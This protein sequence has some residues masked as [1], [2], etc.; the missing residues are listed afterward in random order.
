AQR[1]PSTFSSR[2][3][4][5]T[6]T[7]ACRVVL[8]S[9]DLNNILSPIIMGSEM[10]SMTVKDPDEK[11]TLAIIQESAH[12]GA[13][14]IRQLLTFA[15][16]TEAKKGPVQPRH[17]LKEITRL[18]KQTFPKNIEIYSDYEIRSE[19]MLADPSQFHQVLMNLCVNAR[20][21]MPEGGIL[22]IKL[23]NIKIEESQVSIH[24]AARP[25]TY[26]VFEVSDNGEGI[27]P[28]ILEHIFD[29]FF[30]TKPQGKGSG[31]GLASV[32]GI[33]EGHDGF[34]L[35]DSLP[36][37]GSTFRI[38]IPAVASTERDNTESRASAPLGHGEMVL[39]VDDEK[40]ILRMAERILTQYGYT[41]LTASS[42]SEAK[43]LFEE[44]RKQ[45][46]LALTDIMMPFGDGR[47]FIAYLTEQSPELPIIAISGLS[48]ENFRNS[49]MAHGAKAFLSKPFDSEE[50]RRM[51]AELLYQKSSGVD[52]G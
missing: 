14:T 22:F 34:I 26:V 20:D 31:L 15:R 32:L 44:N 12:R 8:N 29:P 19:T 11:A 42:T 47:Q 5:P 23:E 38:Y 7:P 35:I 4:C 37:K 36:G 41:C 39:I 51:I 24:P 40:A 48:N 27:S 30:T 6:S 10:L 49:V 28:E 50:L 16:G 45:I 46:Q 1:Q 13:D 21:A 2:E 17:L 43:L 9:Y 18:V 3:N 33:V 52:A 25:G